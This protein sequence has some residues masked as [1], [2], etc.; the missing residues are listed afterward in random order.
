MGEKG[1]IREKPNKKKMMII[2]QPIFCGVSRLFFFLISQNKMLTLDLFDENFLEIK[3]IVSFVID[4]KTFCDIWY[5]PRSTS[6]F[7]FTSICDWERCNQL[8]IDFGT[9]VSSWRTARKGEQCLF[10]N[11]LID[12]NYPN[13]IVVMEVDFE[14]ELMKIHHWLYSWIFHFHQQHLEKR[15][16]LHKKEDFLGT[17]KYLSN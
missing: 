9:C 6:S 11:L 16:H 3:K 15:F 7:A 8:R 13:L 17:Y 12:W 1:W 4:R 5:L 14:L 2:I 10:E